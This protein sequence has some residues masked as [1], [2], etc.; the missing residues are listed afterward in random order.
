LP[1]GSHLILLQDQA[2]T[3]KQPIQK[4][5]Y[6]SAWQTLDCGPVSVREE[7]VNGPCKSKA[8]LLQKLQFCLDKRTVFT[9]VKSHS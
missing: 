2:F 9:S 7:F 3:R 5:H 6:N 8:K 1:E 4:I